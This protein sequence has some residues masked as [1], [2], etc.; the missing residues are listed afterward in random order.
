VVSPITHALVGAF[1]GKSLARPGRAF[2]AGIAS[3][4]LLDCLPHRDSRHPLILLLN[5]C[6]VLGV[7][8]MACAAGDLGALA[9]AV[10]GVLPDLENIREPNPHPGVKVFPSHWFSHHRHRTGVGLGVEGLLALTAV[11]ALAVLPTA[12]PVPS[13]ERLSKKSEGCA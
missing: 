1:L 13:D 7:A 3:H 11:L 12:P 6:G 4:A 2:L 10:G 5:A 9:G 8:G